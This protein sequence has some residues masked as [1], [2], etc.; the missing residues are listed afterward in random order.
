MN[1]R[2]PSSTNTI[3]A[4]RCK[5]YCFPSP[6]H[7]TAILGCLQL[8]FMLN[9]NF[10]E[11]IWCYQCNSANNFTCT[12]KWDPNLPTSLQYYIN[13][14]EVF[15]SNYCIKMT[16]IFDGKLGTKRFCSSKNWGN[17]CEYI[18]RPG[19]TQEYRSCVFSCSLSGCNLATKTVKTI[20]YWTVYGFT[21]IS[22]LMVYI[23][24][25]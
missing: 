13:C 22:M 18:K 23:W 17:Y 8:L 11:A 9:G 15:D 6:M 5:V 25:P 20:A 2:I 3:K 21:L 16:G 4:R 24:K 12:E 10:V 14:K 7:V 1:P 19:D